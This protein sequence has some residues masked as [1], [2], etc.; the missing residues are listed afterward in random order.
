MEGIDM[1]NLLILLLFMPLVMA[2]PARADITPPSDVP[3]VEALI[4]LHKTLAKWE[5]A[6]R[7]NIVLGIT[8]QNNISTHTNKFHQARTMLNS[9]LE[10][11][12]QWII[13]AAGISQLSLSVVDLTKEFVEYTKYFT[14]YVKKKPVIAFQY[15]ISSYQIEQK[16]NLL[17]KSMMTLGAS[18]FGAYKASMKERQQMV[19]ELEAEVESIKDIINKSYWWC[20]CVI[21]GD[22]STKHFLDYVT[23]E[24]REKNAA[25][26]IQQWN[27]NINM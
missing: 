1:R 9:K 15:A 10:A 17:T 4:A 26:V 16:V 20:R 12:H 8:E 13:L 5:Q 14:K 11:G 7:N 2:L 22:V 23:D 21:A 18:S 25:R 24:W 3:T 19:W 27:A 6:A